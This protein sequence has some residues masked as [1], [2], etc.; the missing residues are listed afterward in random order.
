LKIGTGTI[1]TG[2]EGTFETDIGE[3]NNFDFRKRYGYNNYE[4]FFSDILANLGF[5][6]CV[7]R[8]VFGAPCQGTLAFDF[9]NGFA[10]NDVF[11]RFLGTPDVG[12]RLN[13][14]IVDANSSPGDSGGPTFIN[15]RIAGVTSFGIT[16]NIFEPGNCGVGSVDPSADS[17]GGCTDSSFGEISGDARVAAYLNFLNP[18][19]FNQRDIFGQFVTTLPTD[20]ISNSIPEPATWAMMITGFGFVGGSMRRRRQKV[21]VTYS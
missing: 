19:I 11:G 14:R 7:D 16:G 18:F 20:F 17:L 1:G 10:Q 3:P 9:D 4:F 15:G 13:G 6:T 21:Q 5:G 12:R 8:D 2:A